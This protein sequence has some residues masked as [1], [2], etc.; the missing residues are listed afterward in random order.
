MAAACN[1]QRATVVIAQK[2]SRWAVSNPR[3]RVEQVSRVPRLQE[4]LAAQKPAVAVIALDLP[5]LGGAAGL[6]RLQ[7]LSPATKI[8]A[9]AR[10]TD[11]DEEMEVLRNGARGY[12]TQSLPAPILD[13]AIEKVQQ[14][15]IWAGRR[16][17]GTLVGE[18]LSPPDRDDSDTS[19]DSELAYKLQQLT[20]RELEIVAL[21]ADGA[22]NKE[23][24]SGLNVS[25]ATVKAHLT[26]IFRKLEQPDRLRLAL[27]LTQASNQL[28]PVSRP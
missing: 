4:A 7:Q 27:Y 24:A 3:V 21:L 10:K 11:E 25:V 15:E 17:I 13:K 2:N 18:L 20:R 16:A 8:I 26:S 22:T 12:V 5:G 23:I 28:L 6:R 14:G 19:D 9:V 1:M